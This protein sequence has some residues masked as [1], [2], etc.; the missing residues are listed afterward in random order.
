MKLATQGKSLLRHLSCAFLTAL[1]WLTCAAASGQQ[2]R[3][4]PSGSNQNASSGN[5][6]G[7]LRIRTKTIAAGQILITLR[8]ENVPYPEVANE[9][10]RLFKAQ[11]ILSDVMKKQRLTQEFEAVPLET[12]LRTLAPFVYIDYE[13]SGNPLVNPKILGIYLQAWNEKPP[14]FDAVVRN[15]SE[16]V[17]FSGDTEET[18][19][20]GSPSK[21]GEGMLEVKYEKQLLSVRT[22]KQPLSVI[23]YEVASKLS[24]PFQ[25]PDFVG[26]TPDIN[27]SQLSL[28]DALRRLSPNVLLDVREDLS[29]SKRLPLR[30]IFKLPNKNQSSGGI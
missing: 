15:N 7:P 27:F 11:V 29:T 12:A 10:G 26:D 30:L 4:Q 14:A 3:T 22:R 13:V 19:G 25:G 21:E 28:T 1:M 18:V 16:S 6:S 20:T 9:L 5:K 24:V 2:D 17:F 8:A 23:L